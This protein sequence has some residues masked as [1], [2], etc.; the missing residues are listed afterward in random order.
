MAEQ[1]KMIE[2]MDHVPKD[3][4]HIAVNFGTY[5]QHWNFKKASVLIQAFFPKLHDFKEL[6]SIT[7]DLNGVAYYTTGV[8]KLIENIFSHLKADQHFAV[9]FKPYFLQ[10]HM[11]DS[12]HQGGL[13]SPNNIDA[14]NIALWESIQFLKKEDKM[15][16]LTIQFSNKQ[17]VF[18][19]KENGEIAYY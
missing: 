9:V 2:V 14:V 19:K 12:V 10:R 11:E 13:I 3:I 6:G 4:N 5:S 7:L 15:K 8:K 16:T 17:I 1:G 18:Y